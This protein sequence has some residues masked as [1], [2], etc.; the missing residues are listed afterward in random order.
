VRL[1]SFSTD[2]VNDT[3]GVL[4]AYGARYGAGEQWTFLTGD[5]AKMYGLI[6][7]GFKLAIDAPPGA[8]IIHSTKLMLVDKTGTVRGFY[9]GTTNDADG[10]IAADAKKLLGE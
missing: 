8:E 10:Q 5:K 3:P 4:K 1:V 7:N 6:K 9:E 2:P